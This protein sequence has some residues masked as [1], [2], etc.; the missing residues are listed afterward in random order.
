MALK[1]DQAGATA[2][3]D[4]VGRDKYEHIII[5]SLAGGRCRAAASQAS[6]GSREQ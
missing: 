5:R 6:E 4:I 2:Q 1:V 3:G